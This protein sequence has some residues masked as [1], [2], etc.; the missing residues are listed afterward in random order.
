MYEE[1]SVIKAYARNSRRLSHMPM[2]C[3]DPGGQP[4]SIVKLQVGTEAGG[5]QPDSML[6]PEEGTQ[7]DGGGAES[8]RSV[9]LHI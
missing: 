3:L 1:G 7:A 4:N 2:S 5:E 6:K 8:S 9:A